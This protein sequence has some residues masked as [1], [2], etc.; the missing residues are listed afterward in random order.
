M[1]FKT[2]VCNDFKTMQINITK[3]CNM[4]CYHCHV[5][6]NPT[7]TESMDKETMQKALEI[8]KKFNFEICDITG[9]AP[10][11]NE[12]LEFLITQASK[13]AKKVI[14]RSNLTIL[15]NE[16][17]TKYMD[18][19][20]K[21][22]VCITASLPCYTEENTDAM[23]GNG[24]F[25]KEIEIIKEL[26][27]LGYGK[28]LELNLVYNPGGAFLPS[29]QNVLEEAYH[30]QLSKYGIIFTHLFCMANVPIGRCKNKLIKE[31]K[32]DEYIKLLKDNYN[33]NNL[34]NLMCAH[35]INVQYNGKIYDC[36]FNGVIDLQE[37]NTYK[38]LDD[39]LKIND[40]K[41]NVALDTHCLA[42]MAASG[43]GCYGSK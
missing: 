31:N 10:E 26:N 13:I 7:R 19:Y 12:N 39:M 8:F 35:G 33:E 17:Y 28:N 11:L 5:E 34:K 9:G 18:I 38:T 14:V 15:T 41:R 36:D 40:I 16:K 23:R 4:N 24:T 3:K 29:P 25:K 6:A 20:A 37:K 2:L 32:Y 27:R 21:N 22:K 30:E 1:N 43:Y 42:C